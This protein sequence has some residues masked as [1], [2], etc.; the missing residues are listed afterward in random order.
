[1]SHRESLWVTFD[2]PQSQSRLMN[3]RRTFVDYVAPRDFRGS[4]RAARTVSR[5][6][7]G[8]KFDLCLSAGAAVAAF[9][10]PLVAARGI[11]THYVESLARA[12]G[13]S[14]TGHLMAIAPRVSTYSQ[15]ESWASRRWPCAGTVFDEWSAEP[16][17]SVA[18]SG[19]R[20]VLVTLGTIRPYRFDR[21]VD[22]VLAIL[23]PDDHVVW[24]LGA[25]RR[26]NL[27]GD[28][29]EELPTDRL[30]AI[31]AESDVVVAHA[32]VGSILQLLE[33]NRCPVLAVRSRAHGEHID[34]HQGQIAAAMAERGLARILDLDHPERSV[35][36][37]AAA[38]HIAQ[39]QSVPRSQG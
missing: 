29:Y 36:E 18:S 24:Q 33:S 10:L 31:T 2:N 4:A 38:T 35:F 37:A 6:V 34:E 16:S 7:R 12:L 21:A 19:P 22:A 11:S 15:Y 32:G 26:E 9:A 17:T 5:I 20:R 23:R 25:T 14:V 13:P 1:M 8:E 3:R 39:N 30:D 28:V 27:P